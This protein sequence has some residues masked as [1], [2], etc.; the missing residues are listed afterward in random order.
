MKPKWILFSLCILIMS[1]PL[2]TL[3]GMLFPENLRKQLCESGHLGTKPEICNYPPLFGTCKSVYTRFYY[4]TLTFVCEPFVFSGCGGNRN[5]FKQKYLCEKY[6]IPE[7]DRG[8]GK[9]EA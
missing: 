6:C 3:S 5:N 4:N 1:M 7:N 2:Q 9:Q 8:G